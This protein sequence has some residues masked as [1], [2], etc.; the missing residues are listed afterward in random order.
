MI[1]LGYVPVFRITV[2]QIE[3][4]EIRWQLAQG[5]Y[6]TVFHMR[7]NT[8]IKLP[9]SVMNDQLVKALESLNDGKSVGS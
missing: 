6:G 8:D 7:G 1:W 5:P 2:P 3:L 9:A 4:A